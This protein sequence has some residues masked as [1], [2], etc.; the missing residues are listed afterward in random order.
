[1]ITSAPPPPAHPEFQVQESDR[2]FFTL[3]RR[4]IGPDGW[5]V[6][7]L[8]IHADES[9]WWIQ[10]GRADDPSVSVILRASSRVTV[11]RVIAALEAWH[12]VSADLEIRHVA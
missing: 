12:P 11:D 10:V 1:M 5:T 8:G 6:H 9:G 7:V 2:L 3:D 4:T